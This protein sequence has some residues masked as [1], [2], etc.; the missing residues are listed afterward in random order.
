MNKQRSH[1]IPKITAQN[2]QARYQQQVADKV[3]GHPVP[4]ISRD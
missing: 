1:F 4:F 2:E 3:Y